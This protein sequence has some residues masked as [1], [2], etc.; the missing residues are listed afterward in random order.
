MV[1]TTA[2]AFTETFSLPHSAKERWKLKG[3]GHQGNN[4]HPLP[5]T[6][7]GSFP[8]WVLVYNPYWGGGRADL[9]PGSSSLHYGTLM[10]DEEGIQHNYFSSD[11]SRSTHLMSKCGGLRNF[12]QRSWHPAQGSVAVF[13]RSVVLSQVCVLCP[14]TSSN[15]ML[16]IRCVFIKLQL[17]SS[18]RKNIQV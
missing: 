8:G 2:V 17:V 3:L 5:H 16:V 12:N 1:E 4:H 14:W 18:K 13:N 9:S 11:P 15:A 7:T 6:P 10:K